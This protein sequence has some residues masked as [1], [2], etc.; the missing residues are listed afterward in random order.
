VEEVG[1]GVEPW[2]AVSRALDQSKKLRARQ[3]E[4]ENLRDEEQE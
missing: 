4:V 3:K 1:V 2:N